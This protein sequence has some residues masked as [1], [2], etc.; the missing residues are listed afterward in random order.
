[1]KAIP[2]LQP[3]KQDLSTLKKSLILLSSTPNIDS[4]AAALGLAIALKRKGVDV[5]VACSADMRVEFSR[6]VGV[7]EVR[8]KI[9]NRNLV[10]SFDYSEEKVEK[11]SYNI[12]EDGKKF[13]LVISPKSNAAPLDPATVAFDYS[14]AESEV[15]FIVGASTFE[16]IGP[17]YEE[18]RNAIE[19]SK[20]VAFTLFPTQ[21]Y[22]NFHVDAQGY[23]SIS[24]LIAV[25]CHELGLEL[26]SDSASNLLFGIESITQG[27]ATPVVTADTFETVAVLMRAGARR[28][29]IGQQGNLTPQQMPWQPPAQVP[30]SQPVP[31]ADG[32]PT[33]G[34]A[35]NP[36]AAALSQNQQK[37]SI[38]PQGY[39]ATGELK[40]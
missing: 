6:L 10:V 7:D 20:T 25:S 40:G 24:E 35:S 27:L 37:S 4:V 30:Q 17:I 13:N 33:Q 39:S 15:T 31:S 32:V 19:A 26:D 12:S 11:V 9:G 21:T 22:A 14:G 28:Q 38:M 3:L 5:Q 34:A 2:V 8:K 18:E 23:S 36:F 16:E 29:P 1:M